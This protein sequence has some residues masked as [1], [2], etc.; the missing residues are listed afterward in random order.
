[1]SCETITILI[2]WALIVWWWNF[3]A[4]KRK[5]NFLRRLSFSS[6]EQMKKKFKK[7]QAKKRQSFKWNWNFLDKEW[8]D[9][10]ASQRIW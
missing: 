10:F 4:E 5:T 1:M 8:E 6:L 7:E 9:K 3:D 2:I